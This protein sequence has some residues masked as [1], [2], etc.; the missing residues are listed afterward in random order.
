MIR[1]YLG[2]FKNITPDDSIRI[3]FN[4]D[5]SNSTEKILLL[6]KKIICIIK[7]YVTQLRW[8]KKYIF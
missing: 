4:R 1:I 8:D 2:T 7:Q 6:L 5:K 3:Q